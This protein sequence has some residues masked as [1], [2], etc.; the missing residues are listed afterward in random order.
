MKDVENCK[1]LTIVENFLISPH[2]RCKKSKFTLFCCKISLL[3]IYAVLP[4]HLFCRD[5]RAF[6]VEKNVSKKCAMWRKKWH[7]W[8]MAGI[9][10]IGK[11]N[12]NRC[13]SYISSSKS[14]Q[15]IR[16]V[17][18]VLGPGSRRGRAWSWA[19]HP[20]WWHLEAGGEELKCGTWDEL[21]A[22]LFRPHSCL[23]DI[24]LFVLV[25]LLLSYLWFLFKVFSPMIL[26]P[27][28]SRG[29]VAKGLTDEEPSF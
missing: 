13:S 6:C 11:I 7:I 8:C 4:W 22:A 25:H 1:I 9:S 18:N 28:L 2:E 12:N 20:W 23:T 14:N 3:A 10:K 19:G 15:N 26:R 27:S 21:S 17:L 5:L 29:S 24:I 16:D